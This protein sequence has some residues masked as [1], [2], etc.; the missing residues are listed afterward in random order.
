MHRSRIHWTVAFVFYFVVIR[1]RIFFFDGTTTIDESGFEEHG[2]REG[3]LAGF[4]SPDQ[5]YIFNVLIIIN[6]HM[7]MF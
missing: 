4:R 6:F 7:R 3:G 5:N 1:D 2:F